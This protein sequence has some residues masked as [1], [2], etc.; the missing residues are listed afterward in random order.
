MANNRLYL[1]NTRTGEKRLLAKS[2]GDGWYDPGQPD[3]SVPLFEWLSG[4]LA[5]WNEAM[6]TEL[7]LKT[8]YEID[9]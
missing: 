6:P 3:N 7:T 5:S 1:V 4:D 2:L 9:D 8:E